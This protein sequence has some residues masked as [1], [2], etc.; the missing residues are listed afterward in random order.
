MRTH[1]NIVCGERRLDIMEE[2]VE[3][4]VRCLGR[5]KSVWRRAK[6]AIWALVG[7]SWR[8]LMRLRWVWWFETR[9]FWLV[10]RAVERC[11]RNFHLVLTVR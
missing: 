11:E 7:G 3:K 9:G 6:A 5:A 10:L 8:A 4:V 2:K 1:S